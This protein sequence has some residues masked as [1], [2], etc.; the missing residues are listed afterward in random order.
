MGNLNKADKLIIQFVRDAKNALKQY[1]KKIHDNLA[2]S[3]HRAFYADEWKGLGISGVN[4]T[5]IRFLIAVDLSPKYAIESERQYDKRRQRHVDLSIWTDSGKDDPDIAIEIK[6][7]NTL[8]P[9]GQDIFSQWSIDSITEDFRKLRNYSKTPNKYVLQ[10]AF[11]P[12][13]NTLTKTQLQRNMD[14]ALTKHI[15]KTN[16]IRIISAVK[17]KTLSEKD[18]KYYFFW[19]ICWKLTK[20]DSQ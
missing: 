2:S 13:S 5:I 19:L 11:V 18:D 20:K 14:S 15:T 9:T 4:E 8:K 7:F 3:N 6:W 10:M 16:A 17:F 1:D 12:K